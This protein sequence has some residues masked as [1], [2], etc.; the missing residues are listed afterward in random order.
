MKVL[1]DIGHPTHVHFYKN[2]IKELE[3]KGHEVLV[4]ARDKDVSIKLLNAYDI[5]Y[6]PVGK[7][8]NTKLDLIYEWI[9]RDYEIFKISR[10]FKPDILMGMLN[11][12]AGHSAKILR[13][14]CFL[15]NDSEVV[16]S[17]ALITYPFADV[18]F[19]PSN[20]GKD[21]G[22][23]QV[24]I[25]GYKELAYLHPNNFIPT[26]DVFDNLDI[27]DQDKYIVMRF[28]AW[29]AGHDIKRK[30]FDIKTKIRFVKELEKYAKVYI[31]SETKLEDEL[32]ANRIN[33]PPEKMHDFLYFAQMLVGDSQT[34]TTEAAVLGTP[35]IRCNSFVGK[36]DM[37]NFTELENKYGLIFNFNDPEKA[38]QKSIEIIQNPEIKTEWKEKRERL[39]KD[40]VDVSSFMVDFIERECSNQ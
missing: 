25:N 10:R 9:K 7:I 24:R 30:G 17:T 4:T 29:N 38:L 26:K 8:G 11:P 22:D 21:L 14:K 31:S 3:E 33:I 6:I 19:T 18:I 1:I 39:L 28:V 36:N 13:K 23:K 32:E 12:C 37:A 15:F 5:E 16:R 20:F 27:D 34:M 40:K 35:A 2:T